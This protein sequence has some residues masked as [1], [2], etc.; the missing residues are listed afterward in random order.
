[1]VNKKV[2]KFDDC[3]GDGVVVSDESGRL[4]VTDIKLHDIPITVSNIYCPDNTPQW[5]KWSKWTINELTKGTIECDIIGGDWNQTFK[6]KDRTSKRLP[7]RGV[8]EIFNT[9]LEVLGPPNEALIDS[10]DSME[11]DNIEYTHFNSNKGASRV[12]R[13]YIPSSWKDMITQIEIKPP[14]ISTNHRAVKLC[15]QMNENRKKAG[16]WCLNPLILKHRIISKAC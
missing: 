15:L 7:S 10:F 8:M 11:V 14:P 6:V 5:L 1:M 4:L 2:A 3:N 13:I 9:L 12:D 16:R